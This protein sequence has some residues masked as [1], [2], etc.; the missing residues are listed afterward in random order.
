METLRP[1]ATNCCSRRSRRPQQF[2]TA[3]PAAVKDSGSCAPSQALPTSGLGHSHGVQ[4]RM[5]ECYLC[6]FMPGPQL[7]WSP[8]PCGITLPDCHAAMDAGRTR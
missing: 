3:R 5:D 2:R 8:V 1:T 6:Q 4:W 7:K